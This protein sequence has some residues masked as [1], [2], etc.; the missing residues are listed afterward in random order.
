MEALVDAIAAASPVHTM[1]LLAFLV[2][3]A[4]SRPAR[5][6]TML[7]PRFLVA[8]TCI[9]FERKVW[10]GM[11]GLRLPL[12]RDLDEVLS[13]PD[14][15][16]ALLKNNGVV[17]RHAALVSLQR[18]VAIKSE[19]SKNKTAG[20]L[21]IRFRAANDSIEVLKVFTK[22]QTG[23]GMPVWL[24][25][26]RQAAEPS[27]CREVDFY[28]IVQ[29]QLEQCIVTP[30]PLLTAKLPWLNYVLLVLEFIDLETDARVVNDG[31]GANLDEVLAMMTDVAKLHARFGHGAHVEVYAWI[32]A[33]RG[34]EFAGFVDSFID[35][36][37]ATWSEAIWS[38]LRERFSNAPM[39]LV[40]GDCRP[41]NMMFR[42]QERE[43]AQSVIFADWEACNV[44]PFLWDLTYCTTLGWPA[45]QRRAHQRRVV[46]AYLNSLGDSAVDTIDALLDVECLTLVLA[47]VSRV[48]RQRGFWDKQGNTAKDQRAWYVRVLLAVGDLNAHSLARQLQVD[49]R[50][51]RAIVHDCAVQVDVLRQGAEA[52]DM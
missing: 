39:T 34:L 1:V 30:T 47:F 10:L 29:P 6:L 26:L 16:F 41:G 17:P 28:S 27:V 51:V 12:P 33:R 43:G 25:A 21:I 45:A 49:V 35:K 48:V 42:G 11:L 37:D 52:I 38:A 4:V 19:P 22:F 7:L 36:K 24:Q 8:F 15:F 2:L 44:G 18:H 14:A 46:D 5:R 3:L 40:H 50:A 9:H 20:S 13:A 23:R 32:P 31:D